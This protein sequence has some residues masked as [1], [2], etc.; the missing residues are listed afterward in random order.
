MS[1]LRNGATEY[2]RISGRSGEYVAAECGGVMP[3]ATWRVDAD[4][5]TYWGHYFK[6]RDEASAD[7]I[8]RAQPIV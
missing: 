1:R 8:E 5:A 4:G 6:T 7:L 3:F 2:A